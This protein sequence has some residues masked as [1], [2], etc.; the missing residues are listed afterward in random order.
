MSQVRIDQ[1][2][3]WMYFKEF[4]YLVNTTGQ[5]DTFFTALWNERGEMKFVP[6]AVEE[7]HELYKEIGLLARFLRINNILILLD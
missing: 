5:V 7:I 6:I 4:N 2:D 1:Q 3:T